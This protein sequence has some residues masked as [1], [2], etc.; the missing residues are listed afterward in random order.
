MMK[1]KL[2]SVMLFSVL[3]M[4]LSSCDFDTENY[5][6]IPTEN[7]YSSVQ[8]LQNGM[9]GAYYALGQYSFLGN[10]A[11][12]YGDF[13]AGVSNGNRSSGH[14]YNQSAWIIQDTDG[15]MA[16][17]WNY[18][19]KVI[20]RTTRTIMGGEEILSKAEQ[21]F[22]D[23]DGVAE[24]KSYV[25][26][27]HALKALAYY[28][29]VNFFALPYHAGTSNLGLPVVKDKP[30]EPFAK[31]SRNTVGETYDQI[32]FDLNKAE[33]LMG[34]ASAVVG[35][36]GY[37]YMGSMAIQALKARVM[38][39]MGKYDDAEAAA[40]KAIELKDKGNGRGSDNQP[41]AVN[42]VNMWSSLAETDEDLFTIAKNESDNLSANAL[43]T[44]YGSYRATLSNYV[45]GLLGEN[46]ARTEL[47]K[48]TSIG[49]YQG[50]STSAATSNIPILRKSEMSLII[51]EVE[52]R[53]GNIAEAQDYLLYTAKRNADIT[54]VAD[55][56]ATSDELMKFI[57]EERVREFAGEGHRYHDARRTGEILNMANFLPFDIS[58]F[59]FPIPSDEINA[60]FCTEQNTGWEDAMP[61]R[62]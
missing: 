59:V 40:K 43:N 20:D 3:T 55:L 33:V 21:L 38:M 62:G 45:W 57:A 46:D 35:E 42:Y 17:I 44:L 10:Y 12:A 29:M 2:Y 27:C 24:A 16:S 26:Q 14:F 60:G 34:E 4:G 56:P 18:G 9:N 50:L 23:E 7:A 52:A 54:S 31:V 6:Q 39:D 5:Q 36:P 30:I 25:A 19:F 37:K 51:A 32:I 22:L 13:C 58:K 61:T 8:D 49:K 48:L 1:S 41:N 28:Y 53:K 47:Y 11:I 15:E